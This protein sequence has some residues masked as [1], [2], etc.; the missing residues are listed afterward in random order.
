M[1]KFRNLTIGY[2]LIAF[3]VLLTFLITPVSVFA[4]S[5]YVLPYPS[6]MPGNKIYKLHQLYEGL[7]K[8]WYFGDFAGFHYNLKYSDKY[9][10]EAKTLFEYKQYLLA[11][12]SLE[13]SNSYFIKTKISINSAK[14]NNKNTKEKKEIL[15]NASAKHKEVLNQIKSITPEEF[16][17]SPEKEKPTKILIRARISESIQIRN[18]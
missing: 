7:E 9:L 16:N 17:W 13:K 10:V 12:Q 1:K 4:E 15:N 2:I 18:L 11:I 5:P 8:Y 6:A 14:S 3:I